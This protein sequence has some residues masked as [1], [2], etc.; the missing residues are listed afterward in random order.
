VQV[1]DENH[2]PVAGAAVLFTVTTQTGHAGATFANNARTFQGTTDA[3]GQVTAKGFHPNGHAGQFHVNV[4][5][6]KGNL[7]AHSSIAQTN[8]AAA[9][10]GATSGSLGGFI[11][12]HVALVSLAAGGAVVGGVVTAVVVTQ[13]P[14]GTAIV[15]GGGT[16]GAP[17][18]AKG[19]AGLRR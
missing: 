8:V 14:S 6:S 17:T 4:T 19:T 13:P 15:A 1:T 2:K 11:G 3:N 18:I 9:T 16:V 5:A 12:T 10:A 7:S